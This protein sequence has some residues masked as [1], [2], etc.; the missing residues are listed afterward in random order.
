M[1]TVTQA[2]GAQSVRK[3]PY[4]RMQAS[5]LGHFEYIL[6]FRRKPEDKHARGQVTS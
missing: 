2:I 6:V 1:L 5:G 3:Q 4:P